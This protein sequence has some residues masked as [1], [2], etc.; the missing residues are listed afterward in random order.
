[1]VPAAALLLFF[2]A[3]P[4][5]L[6]VWLGSTDT[7][8]AGPGRWVGLD[9]YIF[10]I[11]D[12]LARLALFNTVVYTVLAS[13]IKFALGLWLA[14]LLNQKVPFKTLFRSLVL[15]PWIVPTALSAL[16]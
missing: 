4:R 9:N 16:A 7:T 10:L 2:L 3:Y 12:P 13:I 14:L 8:L 11:Q 15:L 5:G 1:M 6:G